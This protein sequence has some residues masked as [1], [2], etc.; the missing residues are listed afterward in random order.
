MK[1]VNRLVIGQ[2]N[3]NSLRNK[4]EDLKSQIIENLD[5]LVI[6]ETK[7]DETF[8][9]GQFAINGF[10]SYRLDSNSNGGGVMIYVREDL[11]CKELK[12]KATPEKFEG[13]FLEINLRKTKW[14][15]FAGYNNTKT[16]IAKYLNELGQMLDTYIGKYWFTGWRF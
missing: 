15:L 11:A 6:T 4:F 2:I 8:P 1:N 7:L 13:I 3:I 12:S 9:Q 16:N 10:S 14:M 5:I